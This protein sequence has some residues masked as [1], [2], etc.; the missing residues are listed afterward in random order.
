MSQIFPD[1]IFLY[2]RVHRW[3]LAIGLVHT[4]ETRNPS[5]PQFLLEVIVATILS[6]LDIQ[7]MQYNVGLLL[8]TRNNYLFC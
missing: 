4:P 1:E 7:M 3:V 8:A 5:L 2:P 6:T